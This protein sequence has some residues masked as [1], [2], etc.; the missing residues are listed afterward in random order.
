MKNLVYHA[1]EFFFSKS[2]VE[3]QNILNQTCSEL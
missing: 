3:L 2:S 1:K